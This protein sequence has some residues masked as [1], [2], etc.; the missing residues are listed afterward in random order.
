MKNSLTIRVYSETSKERPHW[1]LDILD[2]QSALLV[3]TLLSGALD[4]YRDSRNLVFGSFLNISLR[5]QVF[6]PGFLITSTF[7]FKGLLVGALDYTHYKLDYK[8]TLSAI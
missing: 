2:A 3:C 4:S 1:G 8:I 7:F 6:I 5:V